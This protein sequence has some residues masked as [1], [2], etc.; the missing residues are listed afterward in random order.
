MAVSGLSCGLP[1][2]G[3]KPTSLALGGGFLT[4]G[5]PGGPSIC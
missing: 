2:P 5:S 1:P 4:T 3:I